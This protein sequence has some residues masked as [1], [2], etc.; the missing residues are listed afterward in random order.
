MKEILLSTFLE[1]IRKPLSTATGCK[2]RGSAFSAKRVLDVLQHAS[3]PFPPRALTTNFSLDFA[4]KQVL[5]WVL[6]MTAFFAV[7]SVAA[8]Q[9]SQDLLAEKAEKAEKVDSLFAKLNNTDSPGI[10][11]L[12]V[13]DGK[14]LLRRGYGM[15]NLE[16]KIPI[17][18]TTVFD[19]ASVSKQFTGLAVCILVEQGKISLEDDI[20]KYIPELPDFGHKITIEHLVHHT[21]GLRDW[22]ATLALAGWRLDD[23]ISFDQILRMAFK[24]QD[25]NFVPGSEYSYSNTG[26]NILVE[27]AQ[28]V[29]SQTFRQWTEDNI[30]R[31]L[32]MAHTHFHDDHT[33]VVANKAYGY[34]R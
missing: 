3:E 21:S 10:A 6:V 2:V 34:S 26:Y 19:V 13:R 33:E 16:H 4:A 22:P 14:V 28:R 17:T 24:Q 32:G 27:M 25:L 12:V 15:A 9:R 1:P 5:G 29:T 31:P 11:V 30:F 20:R 23:V 7:N 18:P 8:I